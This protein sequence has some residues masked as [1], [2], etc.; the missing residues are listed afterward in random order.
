MA[1]DAVRAAA[2]AHSFLSVTEQGLAAIVTTRSN[3]DC[4]VVLRGGR[5]GPNHDPDSVQRVL[6]RLRAANL[7]ARLM[8]DASHDNSRKDFRQQ[9]TVAREIAAQVAG[10]QAGIFGVMLESFLIEGRQ[11]L[12]EKSALVYGQSITDSCMGWEMTMQVLEQLAEAVQAR[13]FARRGQ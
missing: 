8:I 9:P 4:H 2:T 5:D 6:E 7:P 10:G 13:R 11:E 12:H 3:P 1:V